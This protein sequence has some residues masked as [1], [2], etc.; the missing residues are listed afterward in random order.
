LITAKAWWDFVDS[1]FKVQHCN[2]G[3]LF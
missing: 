1:F 3:T 2:C